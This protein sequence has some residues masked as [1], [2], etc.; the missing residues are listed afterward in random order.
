MK[1][2]LNAA[3]FVLAIVTIAN[4]TGW[5]AEK[6]TT[7]Y[8]K[9]LFDLGAFPVAKLTESYWTNGHPGEVYS[10]GERVDV[11]GWL[12]PDATPAYLTD[13]EKVRY[14]IPKRPMSYRQYLALLD[15]ET[16]KRTRDPTLLLVMRFTL[17]S[18]LTKSV[19]V[20]KEDILHIYEAK[21]GLEKPA[22][23]LL[24]GLL[25]SDDAMR[26][27]RTYGN[28]KLFAILPKPQPADKEYIAFL[29][30]Q[31]STTK[32]PIHCRQDAY[33]RLFA[34]D[35]KTFQRPYREFL[36]NHTKSAKDWY[37]RAHL[38]EGLVQLKDEESLKAVGEGLM[39]DPVT[40]TPKNS[41]SFEMFSPLMA[42]RPA[43]MAPIVERGM[44]VVAATSAWVTP[45]DSIR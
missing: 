13:A 27:L 44:P 8:E 5:A 39:H 4:A 19:P 7:K 15:V 9:M 37:V 29:N 43:N 25:S 35:E 17:A 3:L 33:K 24:H 12:P 28:E 40:D 14:E 2:L 23:V 38:Y 16:Y 42:R 18:M 34:V 1:S 36:L 30:Q 32:W 20:Q 26:L 31:A 22:I 41:A 11:D 45:F 10:K 21:I 6:M